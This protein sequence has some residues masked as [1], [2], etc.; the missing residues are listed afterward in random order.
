MKAQVLQ[1]FKIQLLV[2]FIYPALIVLFAWGD[3]LSALVGC[4]ASLLPS[5]Y[6]GIR[7][8]KQA[9][10]NNAEQWLGYAYRSDIGKWILAGIVFA[11]AFTSGYRWDPIVLF[12]GYLLTQMSGMFLPIIQKGK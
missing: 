3:A 11:L 7:M 10:N 1:L 9:E 2:T 6:F 12:A 4:L 8:L 5:T